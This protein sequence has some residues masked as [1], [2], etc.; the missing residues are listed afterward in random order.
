MWCHVRHLSLLERN[1]QRITR[2]DKEIVSNLNYEGINFP[3][4]RKGYCKIEMQNNICINVFCHENKLM[5]PVH[6]LDQKYEDCM[7]LLLISDEYK[8]Y[9]VYVKNFDR[10]MFNKTKNKTRKY[11]CKCS[12]EF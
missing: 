1:I 3:V 11:F 8:F 6:L 2:E 7:D 9:Y 5:Y 12:S 10:F 4:S